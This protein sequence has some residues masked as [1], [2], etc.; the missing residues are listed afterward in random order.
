MPQ[1]K[2]QEYLKD[3]GDGS[4]GKETPDCAV[5]KVNDELSQISTCDF[6]Y[7]LIDDPYL[8]GKIAVANVLSD[9]YAMG[10]SKI[11][12]V[13]MILGV[14]RLMKDKE[15]EVVTREM[16]RGFNDACADAGTKVTGGQS[17]MNPWPMIGGTAISTVKTK[18]IIYPNNSS[19]GDVLILTKPLG[20]QVVVNSVEWYRL[21]NDLYK[22]F[23]EV[24]ISESDLWDMY[25][26]SVESMLKLNKTAAE[27]MK[28]YNATAA[29]DV[30][31]FGF[32][33][34][35]LNLVMA[36]TRNVTYRID[37]IPIIKNTEK[38]NTSIKDFSLLKGLS[39]ETSGG[40]LLSIRRKDGEEYVK[41][42]RRRNECAWI[43]GEVEE[44]GKGKEVVFRNDLDIQLI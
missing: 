39:P 36:Q 7:P 11:D 34:H 26:K 32:K 35:L 4:I 9:I 22:K 15:R 8:Q 30:T 1:H 13:L 18:E 37:S 25:S 10:V 42:M 2:L 23:N 27:L 38:I 33:G 3:I 16:I 41:E 43:V 24:G 40:L 31:G 21:N 28:K 29:T 12:N 5:F 17:V 20:T 14:S 19:H 44:N 6:F